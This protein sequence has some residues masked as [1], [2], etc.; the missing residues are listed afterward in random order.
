MRFKF[1]NVNGEWSIVKRESKRLATRYKL[2]AARKKAAASV[3]HFALHVEQKISCCP[4]L[5]EQHVN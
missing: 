4:Y 1:E 5:Q 2:H 3:T